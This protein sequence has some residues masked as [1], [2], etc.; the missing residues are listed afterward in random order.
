MFSQENMNSVC[1]YKPEPRWQVATKL[2]HNDIQSHFKHKIP[3]LV[4]FQL[5]RIKTLINIEKPPF[6]AC[7]SRHVW[8]GHS[9]RETKMSIKHKISTLFLR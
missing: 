2:V 6:M 5:V 3:S 4:A 1:L 8:L 9:V 7:L